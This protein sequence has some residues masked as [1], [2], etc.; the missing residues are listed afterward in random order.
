MKNLLT[1]PLVLLALLAPLYAGA[2][3]DKGMA[4]ADAGDYATAA[5]E[6]KQS[7]EQHRL[8]AKLNF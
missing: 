3:V 6:F 2:D 5:K 4:A 1:T 7:A 8:S